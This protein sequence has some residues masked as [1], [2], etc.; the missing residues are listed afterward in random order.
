MT[1][2]HHNNSGNNLGGAPAAGS[3]LAISSKSN[4]FQLY[5]FSYPDLKGLFKFFEARENQCR[6][7]EETPGFTNEAMA[8]NGVAVTFKE[9]LSREIDILEE[10]RVQTQK[11]WIVEE[12]H[13]AFFKD[14]MISFGKPAAIKSGMMAVMKFTKVEP[15]P[16]FITPERVFKI[17][18]QMAFIR[19]MDFD[20]MEHP[21]IK[22]LHF[23]GKIET[24]A[25]IAPFH[26][27]TSNVK[28]V[29][30]VLSTPY[31]IRTIKLSSTGKIQIS[32]K[33][34]EELDA[35]LFMWLFKNIVKG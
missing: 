22:K 24:L 16:V 10:G 34:E 14:L 1:A 17:S 29:K 32:K 7:D 18:D 30:G 3:G 35:E 9:I 12:G 13:F 11:Y 15:K 6:L 33:K 26:S 8:D 5:E 28:S 19:T 21:T 23:D 27:Y 31:G 20:K 2:Q 4:S 25:D